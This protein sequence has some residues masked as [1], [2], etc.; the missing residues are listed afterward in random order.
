MWIVLFLSKDY[1]ANSSSDYL[2]REN[3]IVQTNRLQQRFQMGERK[4]NKKECVHRSASCLCAGGCVFIP[5][6]PDLASNAANCLA[7]QAALLPDCRT[8]VRLGMNR[9]Q[10]AGPSMKTENK[11]LMKDVH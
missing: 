5:N 7:L 11:I 8:P 3:I 6:V 10:K 1:E 4:K 2:L 9:E